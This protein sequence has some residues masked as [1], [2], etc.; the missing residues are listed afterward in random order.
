MFRA[1]QEELKKTSLSPKRSDLI[2]RLVFIVPPEVMT[3]LE[4]VSREFHLLSRE[5][6]L[7]SMEGRD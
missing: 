4:T 6:I 2:N 3:Q 5:S 7:D 1:V